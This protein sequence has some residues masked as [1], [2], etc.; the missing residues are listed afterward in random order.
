MFQQKQISG[1]KLELQAGG[2]EILC[3]RKVEPAVTGLSEKFLLIDF[4]IVFQDDLGVQEGQFI[5]MGSFSAN[6]S[7]SNDQY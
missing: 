2:S 4:P 1:R 5:I 3:F 7:P 6:K